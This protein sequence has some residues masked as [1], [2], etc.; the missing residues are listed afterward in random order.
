MR[1][2]A[3]DPWNATSLVTDLGGD[4]FECVP[5]R[6]GFASMA[7][8]TKELLTLVLTK[9][10]R[11]GGNPVL[12]WMADNLVVRSDPAGNSKPD[13]EKSRERID[14]M[15]ALIMGLDR[16]IRNDRSPS[17]YEERGLLTLG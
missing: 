10:L 15:V 4:G 1:E 12:R 6:Q 9:K 17:V 7:A 5:F 8:P 14:G 3:Y 13:K 11:H 2:I 16:A